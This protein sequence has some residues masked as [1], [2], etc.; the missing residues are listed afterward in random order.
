MR[1]EKKS[2]NES[3]K[4]KKALRGSLL[5]LFLCIVLL[6]GTTFAWFTDTAST[7][8][9]KIQ[10]GNLDVNLQYKNAEQTTY[11]SVT[12]KTSEDKLFKQDVLWEPGHVEYVNLKVSNDGNLA[13]NYKMFLKLGGDTPKTNAYGDS[14]TLSKFLEYAVVDGE[15]DYAGMTDGRAQAIKDAQEAGSK[16]IKASINEERLAKADEGLLYA[17]GKEPADGTGTAS[18]EVTLIVYMPETVGNEANMPSKYRVLASE[19]S[20]EVK[21]TQATVE[22][23]SFNN[24]Y[25]KEAVNS[26]DTRVSFSS[27]HRDITGSIYANGGWG[28][29]ELDT[30]SKY[31][32]SATV[33]ADI[34]AKESKANQGTA[35]M[36]VWANG[37]NA[38]IVINGGTFTQKIT[39][40]SEQYDLIY[41]S[42]HAEITINGGTFKCATPKW[43]LNCLDNTGAKITVNGGKFY[44][45]NPETDNPGEVVVGTGHTVTKDGD[46][47]IVE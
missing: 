14:V 9:N 44:K 32:A 12:G 36:A 34:L 40:T 16:N 24:Q 1:K 23:D 31:T 19:L 47:Y 37:T 25:D 43:T 13:L 28:A 39:G 45:F 33:N 11:K 30:N 27:G 18:K 42:N 26:R 2:M 35:A 15:K 10:A 21:A 46:W 22:S 8:V 5:A 38:S 20:V 41:A 29:L 3:T 7:G 6:I 4:T 17:K